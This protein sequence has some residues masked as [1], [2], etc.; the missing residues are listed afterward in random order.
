MQLFTGISGGKAPLHLN[1]MGIA[2][3]LP[4]S[5]DLTHPLH[6]RQT[7]R[8]ALTSQHREFDLSHVQP[9]AM[10]GSIMKLQA[11]S[12][13]TGFLRLKCFVE[14]ARCMRIQIVQDHPDHRSGRKMHIDQILHC[15]RKIDFGPSRLDFKMSPSQLR[16]Q[17]QEQATGALPLVLRVE[18]LWLTGLHRQ[19]VTD[20]IEQLIGALIEAHLG[21][22]GI[23]RAR[24]QIQHVFHPPDESTPYPWNAPLLLLPRFKPFFFSVRRTVSS[25]ISSTM[26]SW[27]RRSASSCIVHFTRPSGGALQVNAI[28]YASCFS[29]KVGLTPGRGRSLSAQSSPPSTYFLRV[30]STVE[31]P[32]SRTVTISA[33]CFP[34]SANRRI[35]ARARVRAAICPFLV[36]VRSLARSSSLS[37]TRYC[38]LGIT[39]LL[40]LEEHYPKLAYPSTFSW[41]CTSFILK[42]SCAL[43]CTARHETK[44]ER[45]VYSLAG[46]FR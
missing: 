23:R 37:F 6:R 16:F 14:R 9:A 13:P 40:V 18:A 42:H 10:L 22:S 3:L 29:S 17:Q 27:T 12:D 30:R 5:D 38:F 4:G 25:E 15:L 21:R 46:N 34:S 35:G 39:F 2:P 11:P 41:S 45:R 26:R 24:I 36:S 43:Q 7:L 28:R 8:Q 32:T 33:S 19:R 20:F 1:L 31:R 44:G